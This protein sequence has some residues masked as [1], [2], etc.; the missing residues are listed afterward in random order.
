MT[1]RTV[2][3]GPSRT[4]VVTGG[5]AAVVVAALVVLG[6]LLPGRDEG[7]LE[8]SRRDA[9]TAARSAAV[10]LTTYGH[11]TFDSD[12]AWVDRGGTASFADD[13][14]AANRPL[15]TV[16][17]RLGSDA[18]GTVTGA[19]ATV[20]DATHVSVDLLVD[21]TITHGSTDGPTTRHDRITLSMVRRDG[22]WLVDDVRLR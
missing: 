6:V 19:S 21:Q 13:Y 14:R 22:R 16:V 10:E 8:A 20:D 1:R 7:A 15:R 9:L 12:V 4:T 18:A 5:V 17:T 11:A 2:R 3:T